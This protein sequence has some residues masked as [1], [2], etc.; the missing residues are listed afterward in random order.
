[1]RVTVKVFATL[2][3]VLKG[4]SVVELTL[5]EEATVGDL[6]GELGSK[7]GVE[8]ISRESGKLDPTIKILVN[9][10]EIIYLSGLGT[11]LKDGDVIALIPP[12]GGG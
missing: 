2:R 6:I 4:K 3:D 7:F 10:R 9:G 8:V 11:K 12:V 1:M 5:P